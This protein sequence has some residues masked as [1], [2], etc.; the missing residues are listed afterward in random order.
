MNPELLNRALA[1]IGKKI[2][3]LASKLSNKDKIVIDTSSLDKAAKL[4]VVAATK[5]GEKPIVGEFKQDN[6]LVIQAIKGLK[7]T[8]EGMVKAVKSIKV[9]VEVPPPVVNV[10]N[11]N[12]EIKQL[13]Q[14]IRDKEQ[15]DFEMPKTLKIDESQFNILTGTVKAG[16]GGGV[17]LRTARN[18]T[19]TNVSLVSTGTEYSYTF[20]ANT[21]MWVLKLRN[22]GALLYY[23][24]TSG[25]L[26]GSGDSSNYMTV[27]QNYAK[28]V[29][30]VEWS[31]KTIYLG[32][33][34][35]SQVAELEIYTM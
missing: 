13:L 1:Y 28:S 32:A 29:E 17:A 3:D 33:A 2:D 22:Q 12:K 34:S 19:T 30:G 8:M 21:L 11:D 35:N 16:G 27:A 24:F 4:M 15:K 25:T 14:E 31:G 23:S 10:E 18:V 6:T 9:N 7:M 26:P 5:F 20:P